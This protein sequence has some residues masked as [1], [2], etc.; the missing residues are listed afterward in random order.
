MQC[1]CALRN[2]PQEVGVLSR[3]STGVVAVKFPQISDPERGVLRL[4]VDVVAVSI[5]VDDCVSGDPVGIPELSVFND[6]EVVAPVFGLIDPK[7][8]SPVLVLSV[9]VVV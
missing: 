7:E 4:V 3:I 6:T 2:L 1:I 5:I 9:P 8:V